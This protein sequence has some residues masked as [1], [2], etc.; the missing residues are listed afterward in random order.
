MELIVVMALIALTASFAVPQLG[1]GLVSDQVKT[2]ARRLVGM[3]YQAAD[4]ARR[5][6]VVYLM[7]Y[8]VTEHRFEAS[9]EVT[10]QET[11]DHAQ[12][13]TLSLAVPESVL[14][15]QFWS[16]YGGM[17]S[18]DEGSIR[19]TPQGYVEPTILYLKREDGQEMSLILSPFLGTVTV[20]DGHVVPDTTLF[21]K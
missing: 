13:K 19:F 6:Q 18:R 9:P 5:E 21:A 1:G 2:T 12:P 20:V 15:D 8:K 3:V 11:T 7:R 16:W 10:V 4:L 14:V 17:Q